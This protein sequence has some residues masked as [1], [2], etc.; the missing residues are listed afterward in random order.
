MYF[1]GLPMVES[2]FTGERMYPPIPGST[3][4][5]KYRHTYMAY[6]ERLSAEHPGHIQVQEVAE[7]GRVLRLRSFVEWCRLFRLHQYIQTG[8]NAWDYVVRERNT[9]GRGSGKKCAI[10]MT[11]PF[12]LLDIYCGAFAAAF[13]PCLEA[14][15]CLHA[16]EL[17]PENT[18][19]LA[20]LLRLYNG[21]VEAALER[22]LQELRWRGLGEDRQA[23]FA[24][25]IRAGATLLRAVAAGRA[26]PEDWS[27]RS[28]RAPPRRVW[29]PEQQAVLD[30]I[31]AG[32]QPPD[33]A[34]PRPRLLRVTGG[35]GTGKTEV[36]LAA[37]EAA[38]RAGCRVL[39]G[40]P[41]GLLVA[42]HRSRIPA[43]LDITVETIHAAFKVGRDR[44]AAYIPPG[45]LRLYDLIIFDEVS[46]IDATVWQRLQM[47]L[48]ELYPCPFVVFVGDF[49]QLQPVN[50]RQQLGEDLERQV[51]AGSLQ[52]IELLPH[53]HARSTDRDML[54]FLRHARCEQPSRETLTAFFAGRFLPAGANLQAAARE[55]LR[56]EAAAGKH[57]TVLAVTNQGAARFNEA[58][59]A[60]E[61]PEVAQAL[62]AGHGILSDPAYGEQRFIAVTGA[63]VR[64]TQNLDKEKGF[65]NGAMGV[66][67]Q[68]FEPDVFAVRTLE[69]TLL[70]VHRIQQQ[71]LKFL[72]VTYA[73]ATTM[74][75]AQGATLDLVA[76]WFDRRRPDPGYA[77][78]GAS[79]AR[80]RLHVF[81]MGHLRRS[82][83]RPVGGGDQIH[84]GPLSET[85]ASS[86]DEDA[87]SGLTE[88]EEA[89]MD[90]APDSSSESG[91]GP[92]AEDDEIS[93]AEASMDVDSDSSSG[94]GSGPDEEHSS[95]DEED[96]T[97]TSESSEDLPLM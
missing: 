76:L 17:V 36:L 47:A 53:V 64:L 80:A 41:I 34:A 14:E 59:L 55:V 1:A 8:E 63:R 33:E 94:S 58:R 4:V 96:E 19:H 30:A 65:V 23:T 97:W 22:M 54:D 82:D 42:G 45:R 81:H 73:Y 77:Y 51:Q 20:M 93:S 46:Q 92:D 79:R 56:L 12:E 48:G 16:D 67:T 5:N 43:G 49:Q 7:D 38:A 57:C 84:P 27:A 21:D 52:H 37:A 86:D 87:D 40:G 68:V 78:V 24:A 71:R 39:L 2:S 29:S 70:L 75:R 66:I 60:L 69:G 15:L 6:Q 44:D 91:S 18:Q 35:P 31:A 83:W 26:R 10:A 32:V 13:L 11:W 61:F 50:G 9:R 25:R 3:A 90:V 95:P 74:R 62:A 89:S 85:S 28:V 88:S 72:P